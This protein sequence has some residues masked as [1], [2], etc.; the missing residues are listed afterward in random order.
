[1]LKSVRLALVHPSTVIV[2]DIYMCSLPEE[3]F[4]P[5]ENHWKLP[6][7]TRQPLRFASGCCPPVPTRSIDYR[8][9]WPPRS[10]RAYTRRV[11]TKR[12]PIGIRM[13][14]VLPHILR[15][16]PHRASTMDRDSR[17]Q[18]RQDNVLSSL[19]A[20]IEALNLTK[21]VL[22]I[23]PAKA[24]CGSV[25]VILAMIRVRLSLI[26][27]DR[28]RLNRGQDSMIN[29]TDYVELGFACSDICTALGRG[30]DGKKLDD[31]SQSVS[32]AI[33]QLTT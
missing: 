7:E 22:S 28:C 27:V 21:E 15:A 4:R 10:T 23:T 29:E 17:R 16:T 8:L 11:A 31:L 24:V 3:T 14:R 1:M 20:A 9:F 19:N 30:M 26:R 12:P 32:D 5:T 2:S 13:A 18:Q 25:G 6:S 33:G